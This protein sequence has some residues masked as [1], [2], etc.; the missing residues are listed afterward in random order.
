M[1]F[2]EVVTLFMLAAGFVSG[3]PIWPQQKSLRLNPTDA[4]V[5]VKLG[6]ALGNKGDWMEISRNNVRRF[7][8]TQR[9]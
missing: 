3:P 5:H 9:M 4:A 7:A 2:R 6:E 8:W 1:R